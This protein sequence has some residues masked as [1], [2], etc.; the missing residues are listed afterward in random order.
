MGQRWLLPAASTPDGDLPD[1]QAFADRNAH[2]QHRSNVQ[3]MAGAPPRGGGDD[4]VQYLAEAG[5]RRK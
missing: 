4:L 1:A 2:W 5:G 3:R